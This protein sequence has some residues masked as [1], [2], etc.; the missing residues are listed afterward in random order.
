MSFFSKLTG[1]DDKDKKQQK[2][3]R[4]HD[5]IKAEGEF[6]RIF[7]SNKDYTLL[8]YSLGG[9]CVG[10]YDGRLKGNQYLEFKFHGQKDGEELKIEG[11]AAV[12]RAKGEMLAVKFPPQP[13][14]KKFL[15][16]YVE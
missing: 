9:F 7:P 13:K 10:N 8:D 3:V 4:L 1:S 14:L 2:P 15:R 16:N 5:R 6:V 12:V 11:V